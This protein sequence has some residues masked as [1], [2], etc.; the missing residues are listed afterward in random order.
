[1][2]GRSDSPLLISKTRGVDFVR[3]V[4]GPGRGKPAQCGEHEDGDERANNVPV[5]N[6]HDHPSEW[7]VAHHVARHSLRCSA[8]STVKGSAIVAWAAHLDTKVNLS[9]LDCK[10]LPQKCGIAAR[11]PSEVNYSPTGT[12]PLGRM[13]AG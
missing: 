13:P 5:R 10:E 12:K 1:M 7:H 11:V 9:R 8:V 6:Y 3:V 4:N 2:C